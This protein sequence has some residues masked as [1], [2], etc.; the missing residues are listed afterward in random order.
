MCQR[1][2]DLERRVARLERL[3]DRNTGERNLRGAIL[4]LMSDGEPRATAQVAALTGYATPHASVELN[5]LARD[6]KLTKIKR[7]LYQQKQER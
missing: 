6:G 7:G 1:C 4:R 2:I 3:L 5:A